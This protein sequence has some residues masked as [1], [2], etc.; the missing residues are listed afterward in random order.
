[1]SAKVS[2]ALH[3][4]KRKFSR[5]RDP[6]ET[7][8]RVLVRAVLMLVSVRT[9]LRLAVLGLV[10]SVGAAGC[11]SSQ[12]YDANLCDWFEPG[13]G[14]AQSCDMFRPA[15]DP[16]PA[17]IEREDSNPQYADDVTHGC[18]SACAIRFA[19]YPSEHSI[20]AC[21]TTRGGDGTPWLQCSWN[22]TG[23][24]HQSLADRWG[25]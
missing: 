3:T 1:M 18:M 17:V 4:G 25:K 20:T 12:C 2:H 23:C 24:S 10:A 15:S 6:P 21:S 19:N 16:H 8:A 14:Q 13:V 11:G 5:C 7:S 9:L 22:E